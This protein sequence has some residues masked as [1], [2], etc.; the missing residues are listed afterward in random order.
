LND[1]FRHFDTICTATQDRQDAVEKLVLEDIDLMV[2]IGGYNSSNT[3]HLCEISSLHKPSYHIDDSSC[4]VSAGR[5][6]HK[7]AGETGEVVTEG[8]LKEGNVRI[9]LTAGASTPDR[10]VGEVID[11]IVN[12]VLA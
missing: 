10:V 8:W 4:I 9:G 2:I 3:G 1:R 12:C 11:R 7:P 6:R 5:I